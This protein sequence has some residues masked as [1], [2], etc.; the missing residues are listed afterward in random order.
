[1]SSTKTIVVFG[2]TGVQGTALIEALSPNNTFR[3]IALSRNPASGPSKKLAALP[4]TTVAEA[5]ATVMDKPL[6]VLESLGLK[7]GEIHGV[8]SVQGYVDDAAM[9]RQGKAI[10]DA[11][12]AYDVKH[13]VYSSV[14]FAGLTNTEVAGFETKR[15]VENYIL[16]LPIGHTFLR[17]VQFMDI[18]LPDTPF[19]FKM[20]RTVWSKLTYYK[21]P[22]RKHQLI[23]SR[24]IG[25]AGAKAFIEGPQWKDGVVRLAGD[26]MVVGDLNKVY[27]EVYGTDIPFA[28]L[29]LAWFV[30]KVVGLV[31]EFAKFF[32]EHGFNVPIEEVRKDIP[33][34]E[35]YR[36]FLLRNKQESEA[37]AARA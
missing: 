24:D 27:K 22:E 12:V 32:D 26:E 1:M 37:R 28:P 33:D 7:K 10:A 18:W 19:Q 9:V 35:D 25:K 2:A 5:P 36:T 4:N 13:I 34:L 15:A 17:P 3:I 6:E 16:T 30:S 11:A 31:K 21:H 8:F 23:S 29:P 20:G 14:D